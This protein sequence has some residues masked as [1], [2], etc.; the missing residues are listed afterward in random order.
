MPLVVDCHVH[1]V[2]SAVVSLLADGV[3]PGMGVVEHDGRLRFRIPA[4]PLS[5]PA[6]PA[7]SD[8]RAAQE[9][10]DQ[11]GV[12]RLLLAPWT[13]LLGYTLDRGASSAWTEAY[14]R[15]L[16][17]V[18]ADDERF[19]ALGSISLQHPALAVEQLSS[20]RELG[21]CGA[22]I[23]TR[24]P[25]LE[26]DDSRLDEVWATA[27]E[28]G[29]PLVVHPIF[30]AEDL[31]PEH[32]LADYALKNAVGR[33]NET[34]L[35]IS[36]LLYRGVMGAHPGLKLIVSHGGGSLPMLLP[37][38]RRNREVFAPDAAD[39]EAE[40]RRLY[41]DSVVL[42]PGVLEQVVAIVGHEHVLLGSDYPFPWETAPR[43]VVEQ[44]GLD[45]EEKDAILGLNAVELFGLR[46]DVFSRAGL[47]T[48]DRAL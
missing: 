17:E 11:A 28:L 23:G 16:G 33:A 1:F 21:C 38:L 40:F 35:A 2:P 27:S 13:D 48:S 39:P 6:P 45:R 9:W 42:D 5:P 43:A 47:D 46:G 18:A 41:L 34:T 36:R 3:F 32:R 31:A 25:N 24:A 29:L 44:S 15:A 30:F 8:P 26:L 14:N 19:E 12:D 4:L 7:M 20:L 10:M 22:M 37:R